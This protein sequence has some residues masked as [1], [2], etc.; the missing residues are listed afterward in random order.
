MSIWVNKDTRVLIQGITGKA[1]TYHTEQMIK[2]GTKVVAGTSPSKGG[3]EHIGVKVFN[4]VKEAVSKTS[5][6]AS[7][8][9]VPAPFAKDAICE[10]AD[11]GIKLI[12]CITEHI[13]V[14][15]MIKAKRFV[16]EKGARLIGPNCPGITSTDGAKLGIM[17]AS[18]HRKGKIGIVSRSG[19]LTYEAVDAVSKAGLGQ[20]T[21]I[22]IGGDPVSGTSF[23]DVLKAFN[24]DDDTEGVIMIGEIGGNAEQEAAIWAKD[25][26]KKPLVAFIAGQTAPKG[27][28]MGHAGAI[29]SGANASAEAKIKVLEDNGVAVAKRISEIVPLLKEKNNK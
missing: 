3:T 19:T 8:I 18:I 17:P 1:A 26:F 4:T 7:V 27:K 10:A 28:R 12:V 22:G 21:A 11:A 6:D 20:S 29:V 15:D 23:L 13:P 5:P 25:N 9:F 2:Y 14:Q 16:A 24:Q